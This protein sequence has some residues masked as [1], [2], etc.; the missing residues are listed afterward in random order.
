MPEMPADAFRIQFENVE[1]AVDSGRKLLHDISVAV[2]QGEMLVLLGRS[3]SGKTTM[4]KL[5]NRL[6]EPTS[7]RLLVSG[8]DTL[9][10]DPIRLRRQ[11]G[12]VIQDV[13]LFPHFNVE[14]NVAVVPTLE[15]WT[16]DRIAARVD[17]L[18]ELVGLPPATF[19]NRYPHELSGGQ[20][21][22][23]GVARALAADPPIL[24]LDEPFGALDPITRAEIQKEFRNLHHRLNKTMIFVTHDIREALLLGTR[25][26]LM[27]EGRLVALVDAKD[28]LKLEHQEARA[29]AA[30]L[31]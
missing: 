18:L 23:V 20:R 31:Q 14:R 1:Y 5:V 19:G 2:R 29:F 30:C 24:L 4:L 6:L 12:Y 3:G 7:G 22:R 17:E 28:F 15:D 26:G 10:W 27:Q 25:I 8:K 13:G 16:P 11:I 9:S 21:Q